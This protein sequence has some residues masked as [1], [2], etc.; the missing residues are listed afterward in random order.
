MA[1]GTHSVL[2]VTRFLLSTSLPLLKMP[3]SYPPALLSASPTMKRKPNNNLLPTKT[4][5]ILLSNDPFVSHSL[6]VICCP[7]RF[8]WDHGQ[9]RTIYVFERKFSKDLHVCL[10]CVYYASPS[11]LACPRVTWRHPRHV[12][13]PGPTCPSMRHY[14]ASLCLLV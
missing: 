8:V 2:T 11:S 7:R 14:R 1:Q 5:L 13:N 6:D 9:R 12:I 4:N 10:Q 3:P